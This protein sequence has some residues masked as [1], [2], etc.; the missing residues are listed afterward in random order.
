MCDKKETWGCKPQLTHKPPATQ[1]GGGSGTLLHPET[2]VS[3][4]CSLNA[5]SVVLVGDYEL[6]ADVHQ[7]VLGAQGRRHMWASQDAKLNG[8]DAVGDK[9]EESGFSEGKGG[10]G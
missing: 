7:Q 2:S 4:N 10:A 1:S 3:R 8:I 6:D 9:S 5:R